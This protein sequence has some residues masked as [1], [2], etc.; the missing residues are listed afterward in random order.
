MQWPEKL[1]KQREILRLSGVCFEIFSSSVA[2]ES[3]PVLALFLTAGV[4]FPTPVPIQPDEVSAST[5][6]LVGSSLPGSCFS[7]LPHTLDKASR[8]SPAHVV[9]FEVVNSPVNL[10]QLSCSA[11]S[12]VGGCAHMYLGGRGFSSLLNTL[13][14]RCQELYIC[15]SSVYLHSMPAG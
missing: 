4:L 5:L 1:T 15:I 7:R 8:Q 6:V 2:L 11:D 9:A 13:L 3:S 10:Q 12:L 14:S